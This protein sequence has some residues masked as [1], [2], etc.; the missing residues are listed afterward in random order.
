MANETDFETSK[1]RVREINRQIQVVTTLL[2]QRMCSYSVEG[3][4]NAL[5]GVD[6][7]L[8]RA[9]QKLEE[10]RAFIVDW[11]RANQPDGAELSYPPDPDEEVAAELRR[12]LHLPP[13]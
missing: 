2:N 10:A 1:A 3:H 11:Q 8:I 9:K 6:I 12:R 7:D 5:L 13:A 4:N